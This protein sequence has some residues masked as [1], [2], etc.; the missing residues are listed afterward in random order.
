MHPQDAAR[1]AKFSKLGRSQY[2]LRYGVLAWGV[3]VAILFV[4]LQG[5]LQGWTAA[6]FQA[7][8]ALVLFPLGGL[9]Y[10]RIMWSLLERRYGGSSTPTHSRTK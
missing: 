9:F 5:F 2:V 8:P 10:G 4:L 1:W 7:I 6:A 3:P